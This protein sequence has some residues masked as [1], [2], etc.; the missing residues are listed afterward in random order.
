MRGLR[1]DVRDLDAW[2]DTLG[3]NGEVKGGQQTSDH[4]L[5]KLD[6]TH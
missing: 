6:G 2:I 1:Y 5:A 3:S 4:W